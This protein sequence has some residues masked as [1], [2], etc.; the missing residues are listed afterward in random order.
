MKVLQIINVVQ[1]WC[2][3]SACPNVV[4]HFF[5]LVKLVFWTP[6]PS[7]KRLEAYVALSDLR[8]F[9]ISF[10]GKLSLSDALLFMQ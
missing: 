1:K 8:D 7:L 10:V 3:S 2:E 4:L 6:V 5:G 9:S